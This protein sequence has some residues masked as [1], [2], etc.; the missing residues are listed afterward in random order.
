MEVRAF[1]SPCS[2]GKV[3]FFRR[4]KYVKRRNGVSV[5]LN[6]YHEKISIH[7]YVC[8]YSPTILRAREIHDS[9]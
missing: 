3:S 7:I 4:I 1:I 8:I 5:T 6:Y 9:R 2:R